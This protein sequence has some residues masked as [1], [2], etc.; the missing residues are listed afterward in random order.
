MVAALSPGYL[1]FGGNRAD[2]IVYVDKEDENADVKPLM[3]RE[4]TKG[5]SEPAVFEEVGVTDGEGGGVEGVAI[6]EPE[7]ARR[8]PDEWFSHVVSPKFKLI[9]ITV[10]LKR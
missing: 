3:F 8:Y 4:V 9:N 7:Y 6:T 5:S 10:I 2:T 1:R